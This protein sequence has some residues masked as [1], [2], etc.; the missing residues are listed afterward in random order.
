MYVHTFLIKTTVLLSNNSSMQTY[1]L[2]KI[3]GQKDKD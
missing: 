1:D 3:G 2:I